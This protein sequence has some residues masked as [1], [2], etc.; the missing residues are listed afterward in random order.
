MSRKIVMGISVN[1]FAKIAK[2]IA[3]FREISRIEKL[4]RSNFVY[5]VV[6]NLLLCSHP[7]S[8]RTTGRGTTTPAGGWTPTYS[9]THRW[10]E[11]PQER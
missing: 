11:Q 8:R 9:W 5:P 7:T 4:F 3:N 1:Y 10:R 2:K 6:L